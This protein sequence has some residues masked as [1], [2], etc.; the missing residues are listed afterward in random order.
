MSTDR[1]PRIAD[2]H[3]PFWPRVDLGRLHERLKL[4]QPVSAASLLSALCVV[5]CC[6][7]Y[8]QSSISSRQR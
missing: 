5:G 1:L 7:L 4:Q 6:D 2:S 3:D 8:H